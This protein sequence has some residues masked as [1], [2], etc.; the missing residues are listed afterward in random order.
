VIVDVDVDVSR[1]ITSLRSGQL[2]HRLRP[3][4]FRRS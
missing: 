2:R 3:S 1:P 4:Q